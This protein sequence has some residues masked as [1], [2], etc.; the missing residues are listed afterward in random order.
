MPPVAQQ[1]VID[2]LRRIADAHYA[3]GDPIPSAG[4][5]SAMYDAPLS[6]VHEAR[7]RLIADG[8]LVLRPGVGTVVAVPA[9]DDDAE[10][11]MAEARDRLDA[12]IAFLRRALDDPDEGVRWDPDA[13]RR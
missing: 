3:P 13:G 2:L 8:V 6:V 10:E 5:L 11:Q 12:Q 9:A 7:R 1:I 4:Q